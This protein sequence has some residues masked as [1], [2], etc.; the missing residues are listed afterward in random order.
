MTKILSYQGVKPDVVRSEPDCNKI[1]DLMAKQMEVLR[2]M[3]Q[4]VV[5]VAEGARLRES[6][7][8]LRGGVPTSKDYCPMAGT[9]EY[10]DKKDVCRFCSALLPLR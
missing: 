5:L 4:A 9:H 7:P 1:L 6:E 2:Q 10:A 8:T 3:T